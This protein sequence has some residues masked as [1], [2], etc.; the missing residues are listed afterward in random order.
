MTPE[1]MAAVATRSVEDFFERVRRHP[2]TPALEVPPIGSLG[3]MVAMV[4]VLHPSTG[5]VPVSDCRDL[6]EQIFRALGNAGIDAETWP[7][8]GPPKL[9]APGG[10]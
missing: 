1:E 3:H 10:Y 2:E 4:V 8:D 5:P 7:Y 9:S 6:I